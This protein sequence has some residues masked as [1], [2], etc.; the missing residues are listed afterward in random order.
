MKKEKLIGNLCRIDAECVGDGGVFFL[1]SAR[2][3]FP[4]TGNNR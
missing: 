1:R 3:D 4:G 2:S